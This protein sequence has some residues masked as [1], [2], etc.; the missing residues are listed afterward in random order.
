MRGRSQL[1]MD[2]AVHNEREISQQMDGRRLAVFVIISVIWGSTWLVI[3]DQ[4]SAVPP[5][6]TICWRFVLASLGM[7]VLAGLRRESMV[8]SREGFVLAGLVGLAQFC[9]NFQMVYRAEA[10]VTSGL[11]AVIY[12]LL[13]V[14]NAGL[15]RVF[16][17]VRVGGRFVVGSLV[18]MAGIAALMLQEFRAAPQMASVGLGLVLA[19]AGLLCA[20]AGNIVQASAAGRRQPVVPLLAWA[21]IA[22]AL[23]DAIIA[24]SISGPPVFDPRPRYWLGIGWLALVGSVIAFPLYFWLIRQMGAGRAAYTGVAIPVVAMA[25]STLFEGYHWTLLAVAGSVLAMGGLVIA[26]SGKA[27][28]KLAEEDLG[29]TSPQTP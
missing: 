1:A 18:A 29:A 8:L 15:A 9:A 13:M 4:I 5:G 6:W 19:V 23:A 2:I 27:G 3:K 28:V 7:L 16:L 10:H 26:L 12:A 14:P 24:Y 21:M 20:S 25:L 11:V 17:G 22:G